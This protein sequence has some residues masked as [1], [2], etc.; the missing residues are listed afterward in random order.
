MPASLDPVAVVSADVAVVV[1]AEASVAEAAAVTA[2]VAAAGAATF[3]TRTST[4]PTLVPPSAARTAA[5]MA[6]EAPTVVLPLLRRSPTPT[7]ASRSWFATYVA[8]LS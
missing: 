6:V 4:P 3:L 7:P 2:A 5:V 8:R 1:S